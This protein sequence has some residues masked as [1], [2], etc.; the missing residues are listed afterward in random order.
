MGADW[1]VDPDKRRRLLSLQK[2][3]ENR[4]CFDCGANNPQW[5]S[6]KHGIFICLE[7][8]G[9][10][11]GLGVHIS[12]VRSVTMDQFKEDEMKSMEIGGNERLR[13]YF[14]TEGVEKSLSPQV[15]YG[16]TVAEDYREMLAAEIKGEP[17]T[18]RERPKRIGTPAAGGDMSSDGGSA[19]S[20]QKARNEAYF[21]ELGARNNERPEGVPPSQGGRFAG[22][23]NTPPPGG[24]GGQPV[25]ASSLSLDE[26]QKDPLGTLTKGWGLF[27]RAVTKTAS[28]VNEQ[29]IKPTVEGDIGQNARKAMMQFGQKMQDT[30]KYAQ[31]TFK[32]FTDE[33]GAPSQRNGGSQYA[34]LFD[35]VGKEPLLG[36]DNDIEPAFGLEKPKERTKLEGVG[37]KKD[38]EWDNW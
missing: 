4:Q 5:A 29:Y 7:C 17:W 14:E 25:T 30:G 18:R 24:N 11:R 1:T 26:L 12:F 16:S 35:G 3:G 8:A 27:S 13:K 37:S 10:H 31:E 9:V 23:G 20:S 15:K 34:K 38:D 33:H 2:T 6:P 22:F 21:A 32:Q 28:E 36:G 19:A